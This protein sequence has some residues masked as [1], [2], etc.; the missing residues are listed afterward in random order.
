MALN[1]CTPML[2]PR[3]NAPDRLVIDLTPLNQITLPVNHKA[4]RLEDVLQRASEYSFFSKIDV[5]DA[6]WMLEITEDSKELTAFDTPWGTFEFNCLP[7]GW[8]NSPAHW[9]RYI[10]HILRHLIW[11]C[12]HVMA[13]DIIIY[14][15]T[16]EDCLH[17]TQQVR[18]KLRKAGLRECARKT[19]VC[20]RSVTYF[21]HTLTHDK[22]R[23]VLD[24]STIQKWK[25]PHN[26]RALQQWLGTINVFRDHIPSLSAIVQPMT[27]LTG[28]C[29]WVWGASQTRAF[30]ESKQAALSTMW[31]HHHRW[32]VDQQLTVDASDKGLGAILKENGR[33]IS[34][35]SR[36]LTTHESQYDTKHRELLAVTWSTKLLVHLISD[37]PKLTIFTDHGNLVTALGASEVSQ[38]V[39]RSIDWLSNFHI[40]WRHIRGRDNPAD[41][42]SRQWDHAGGKQEE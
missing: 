3:A 7:Q 21:G 26:K 16:H 37:S 20:A 19:I 15:R 12:C 22:W 41:G 38:R 24:K 28:D 10:S 9:Q 35:V 17:R 5:E 14:G 4:P 6:F 31:R 11:G 1:T 34:V 18:A 32:G 8:N 36:K 25:T 40:V 29:K 23:P 2:V 33:V 39:N 27:H 42:P 30:Q 13:D